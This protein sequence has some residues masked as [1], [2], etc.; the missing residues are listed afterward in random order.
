MRV[1]SSYNAGGMSAGSMQGSISTNNTRKRTG[2]VR[3]SNQN[4]VIKKR[5]NYNPREIRS[6]LLRASRAQSAGKVLTQAKGKLAN[7]L[8]AKGTGQFNESELAAAIIHARRMV[9]CAQMKTQN[10]KQE[11]Q[12]QK[13]NANEAKTEEQ[14]RK[15]DLKLRMKRKEQ[16]LKQK[17]RNEKAQNVQKQK[18]QHQQ[19]LQR[20]R[21][22]RNMEHEKMEE[23]DL[24]YKKNMGNASRDNSCEMEFEPAFFPLEGVELE[25]SDDGME[26]TE[27]QIEQQIEQEVAMAM[28]A[29]LSAASVS[30]PVASA[31]PEGAP[32]GGA[33]SGAGG[34]V[35]AADMAAGGM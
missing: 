24:E 20:R 10:L 16:N 1:A 25:L 14:Q 19:L 34:E 26:L 3:K 8:R 2:P 4:K 11:E 17:A 35:P 18:R 6:A 28:A 29:E 22:H 21:I 27:A 30:V 12:M 13:K 32:A 5:V 31:G 33:P 9:R 23:A 15:N 7:L